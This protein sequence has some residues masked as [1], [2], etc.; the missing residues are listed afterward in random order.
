MPP[1]PLPPPPT[2]TTTQ[3]TVTMYDRAGKPVDVPAEQ[4]A[5]AYNS[6][7]F[8]FKGSDV[9]TVDESGQVGRRSIGDI[10]AALD[11]GE[12]IASNGQV[13]GA[14]IEAKYGG[15]GGSLAAA[16]EGLVRGAS[17]GLSDPL[18]VG[19]ARLLGG[20]DAAEKVR[21]HLA[22]EREA[23]GILSTGGELLGAG[24]P[25]LLSGGATA[26]E[27]AA[28]AGARAVGAAGEAGVFG[29][30]A[31]GASSLGRTLGVMPRGVGM[32]GDAAE[33]AMGAI[34]G[35]GA[36]STLGRAGQ[37]AARTAARA[38]TEAG[39]FGGGAAISD[40][41]LENTPLTA[42]KLFSAVGHS[43]LMGGLIGG[44]LAGTG[45]M[46]SGIATSALEH[47]G[48]KLEDLAGYQ[49]WKWLSPRNTEAKLAS[50]AGGPSAVGRTWYDL[51]MRPAVDE[52]GMSAVSAW[53]HE[54]K[55]E[56]TQKALDSVGK[57]VASI[58]DT[59]GASVPFKD[60]LAPIDK[61]IE[62]HAGKLLGDDKVNV[63]E[64]LKADVVRILGGADIE[65]RELGG[66]ARKASL[67]AGYQPGS[68]AS[69][70]FEAHYV[71]RLRAGGAYDL[72]EAPIPIGEAIRQRRTLQQVAFSE[73]QAMDPKLR[74]QILRDISG[75]W[76]ELEAKALN[77]A[78][79]KEGGVAGDQ[80]RALNKQF[81]QLK[82]AETTIQNT[83]DRYAANNS[84]SLSDNLYGAMHFGGMLAAGHPVG[85][86]GAIATSYGHKAIR[87]R[88]N[89]YAAVLLD[90]L[91]T[92]GGVARASSN[93]D[94]AIDRLVAKAVSPS[95]GG[96]LPRAFV[97]DDGSE[98]SYA[99]ERDRVA[100]IATMAPGLIAGHLQEKTSGLQ[101]HAPQLAI[102]LQ[103]QTQLANKFLV[104]KLPPLAPLDPLQGKRQK[105]GTSPAQRNPI[106]TLRAR[107][108][109]GARARP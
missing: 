8:A 42:E 43:A 59:S 75:D 98:G 74:V 47:T 92:W 73:S 23:H 16:G 10:D 3:D 86:L 24:A 19:A 97:V 40:S 69:Q 30:I 109:R 84:L 102:A 85:A 58:A 103:Q 61:R 104:S 68:E 71:E 88:G 35:E 13:H 37:A 82:V 14:H 18:A 22:E 89:A 5:E 108:R 29:R 50:R 45:S 25:M 51:V 1:D 53:S 52:E 101:T 60:F 87:M 54:K 17:L 106:L 93:A 57:K 20:E 77:E 79:A 9:D 105:G 2:A 41:T 7:Q 12:Q 80:F 90:R 15:L 81:Q 100:T 38:V 28:L 78:S 21:T 65:E 48:P 36:E 27:S 95:Q 44:G 55:L 70:Q 31:E 66:I 72:G 56:A 67:D 26:P 11:A 49:A 4:A 107:R 96:R 76:N 99:K 64:K 63:L 83:T 94:E 91:S 46:A 32:A 6:G 33:H 34:L 62:E 39:L